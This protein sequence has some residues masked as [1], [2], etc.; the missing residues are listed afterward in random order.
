MNH[1]RRHLLPARGRCLTRRATL[2]ALCIH[3]L[4]LGAC[5]LTADDFE[6]AALTTQGSVVIG[7]VSQLD[8]GSGTPVAATCGGEQCDAGCEGVCAPSCAPG[9]ACSLDRDCDSLDCVAGCCAPPS[10][11]DAVANQNESDVDCGG[12]C[13]V[14]CN[15]DQGCRS[16]ADCAIGLS[17]GPDTRRCATPACTDGRQGGT[18]ILVDCGG[19]ECPGC[20]DGTSCGSARDCASGSCDA[21][22]RC[23]PPSC[24]DGLQ[25]QDETDV[26]C[27]G[28][29]PARC[30]SGAACDADADCESDICGDACESGAGLCCQAAT[31][32]D[33]I[34]NAGEADIDCGGES[35][36][37]PRC[38]EGRTCVADGDCTSG[39]CEQGRCCGGV[40]GDCTR[41]AERL[42]VTQ[43]CSGAAEGGLADCSAFLEC[44]TRN[45]MICTTRLAPGCSN[46]PGG[47]CNHNTYGGNDGLG[48]RQVTLVLQD[49]ACTP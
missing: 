16:D 4:A 31:C 3:A 1:T 10:C 6:P 40:L 36:A 20:P 2:L 22:A 19:G 43:S 5:T 41:C 24:G 42:S 21:T 9:S 26:D 25:N 23:A 34:E 33:G 35:A 29:C 28:S 48:L 8:A 11:E 32:D 47:V 46:D 18:E 30:A 37:C 39:A 38:A 49:A 15:V 12:S 27:G 44:L 14:R 7:D 13:D 17:C 45:A